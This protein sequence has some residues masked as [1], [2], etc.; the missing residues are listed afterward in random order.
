VPCPVHGGKDGFCLFRDPEQTGEGACNTSGTFHDGFALLMWVNRCCFPEAL[1]VVTHELGK[2]H[3]GICAPRRVRALS[4]RPRV[5]DG[6]SAIEAC[7]P[8]LAAGP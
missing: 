3:D 6:E 1:W 8:G 5:R 2:A 7:R 4:L